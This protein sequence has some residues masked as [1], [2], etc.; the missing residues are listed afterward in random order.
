MGFDIRLP[1]GFLFTLIGLLLLGQ[2]FVAG[3]S[4]APGSTGLP[5][6]AA[7]GGVVLVFGLVCLWL[8]KRQR[9]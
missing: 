7:W 9:P 2:G 8:A 3:P 5:V 4:T 1:V 6:N